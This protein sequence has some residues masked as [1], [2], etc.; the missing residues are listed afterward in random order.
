[1][2]I[3]QFIESA[4]EGGWDG[5]SFDFSQSNEERLAS[6]LSCLDNY[7]AGDGISTADILLDPEAWKAVGK[8]KG[9]ST[10]KSSKWPGYEEVWWEEWQYNMH[11]MVDELIAHYTL[12]EYIATL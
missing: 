6:I 5:W 12:E 10:K 4:I 9:W 8:I 2:T 11:R 3:Q 7:D 1:M